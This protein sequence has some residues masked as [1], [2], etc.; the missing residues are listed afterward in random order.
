MAGVTQ[1]MKRTPKYD[2]RVNRE[3]NTHTHEGGL[4]VTKSAYEELIGIL[5]T[6]FNEDSFYESRGDTE[7]RMIAVIQELCR[8]EEGA[9]FALKAVVY[10]RTI[11]NMRTMPLMALAVIANTVKGWRLQK[12]VGEAASKAYTRVD[13]V[14][15]VVAYSKLRYGRIPK[16]IRQSVAGYLDKQ[17]AYTLAKYQRRTHN[18][19]LRDVIKLCHPSKHYDDSYKEIIENKLRN[20][21]TWESRLSAGEKKEEVFSDLVKDKKIGHMALLRNIRNIRDVDDVEFD[22]ALT[23]LSDEEKVKNGKQFPFRY[24]S[25]YKAL[26]TDYQEG[27]AIS[28]R[29]AFATGAQTKSMSTER[30]N[31]AAKALSSAMLIQM[32]QYDIVDEND[33][34]AVIYDLS[35]SMSWLPVSEK[36]TI[37]MREVGAVLAAMISQKYHNVEVWGFATEYRNVTQEIQDDVPIPAL[38]H[39]LVNYDLGGGTNLHQV[40]NQITRSGKQYTKVFVI[41]DFQIFPEPGY[42]QGY[43]SSYYEHEQRSI[44]QF[45]AQN[46]NATVYFVDVS[47][48]GKKPVISTHGSVVQIVGFSDN[49]FSVAGSRDRDSASAMIAEIEESVIL[50]EPLVR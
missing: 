10:A 18:F 48:Y 28:M 12:A 25:A 23:L 38:V 43:W 15:T 17:N 26:C 1:P 36:S 45:A 16:Y 39:R 33:T 50:T 46:P 41:S 13:D 6:K 2:T 21:E 30:I 20:K 11:S 5:T 31:K 35:G 42:A 3:P 24:Y 44:V 7:D 40:I 9:L 22:S 29:N 49:I 37:A 34:V 47:D 8:T 32:D 14:I 4:A 27:T 19:K